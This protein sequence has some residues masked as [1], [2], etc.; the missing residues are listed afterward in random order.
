MSSVAVRNNLSTF[1]DALCAGD[2]QTLTGA[3]HE[4]IARAEDASELIGKIG[5]VAMRGDTD[6]H[7]VLTLGAASMLCRWLISLRHVMGE[8]GQEQTRGV[9]L[10]VQ[11]LLAAAPAVRVGKDAPQNY[12]QPLFPGELSTDE[13]AVSAAMQKAVFEIGR[14]HV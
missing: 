3:A 10:A 13:M 1:I 11:A 2:Q 5:L 6:G 12:P 8:D 7:V 14:A 9:E 4:V